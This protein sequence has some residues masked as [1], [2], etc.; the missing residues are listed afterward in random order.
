VIALVAFKYKWSDERVLSLGVK[1]FC[2]Y[3]KYIRKFEAYDQLRCFEAA[4]YP[5]MKKE[6]REEIRQKYL[7]IINPQALIS[8]PAD[9]EASWAF[10]RKKA[11]R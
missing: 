9:V 6:E 5:Y 1:K 2:V 3:L 10:L 7:S 8:N 4:V 11:C